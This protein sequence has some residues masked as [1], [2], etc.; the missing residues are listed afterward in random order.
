MR[1]WRPWIVTVTCDTASSPRTSRS[2]IRSSHATRRP[3]FEPLDHVSALTLEDGTDIFHR[4]IEPL[5]HIAVRGLEPAHLGQL[6]VEVCR[7][8]GA[9]GIESVNLLGEAGLAAVNL[10]AAL[11]RG[12]EQIQRISEG[13]AELFDGW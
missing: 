1:N 5:R 3:R 9:I 10:D 4:S 11:D 13:A 6:R 7:K 2:F 8:L 12:I